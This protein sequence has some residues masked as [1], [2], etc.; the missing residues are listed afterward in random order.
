MA[1]KSP[2]DDLVM[3]HIRNARNFRVPDE[4][5]RQVHGSNPLCGG[6]VTV[7]VR[8]YSGRLKDAAFQCGCRGISMTSTSM[9][10]ESITGRSVSEARS[11]ARSA[12]ELIKS[13]ADPGVQEGDEMMSAL[14]ATVREFAARAGCALLPWITLEAALENRAEATLA[15]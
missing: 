14:L 11:R 12:T 15:P 7:Y 2:Y 1:A 5:H 8:T 6:D 3:D 9:M 13:R 10:T 4:A